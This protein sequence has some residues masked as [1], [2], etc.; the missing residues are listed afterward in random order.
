MLVLVAVVAVTS[1]S[2]ISL[3]LDAQSNL[4]D[5]GYSSANVNADESNGFTTVTV[6]VS[7]GPPPDRAARV[8]WTTFPR[9]VDRIVVQTG[10]RSY[11]YGRSELTDRF[12]SR[13]SGYDDKTFGADLGRAVLIGFAVA[14]GGYLL[15]GT[16]ILVIALT[17][18]SRKRRA[19]IAA[20]GY[21]NP[22]TWPPRGPYARSAGNPWGQPQPWNQ[23]QPWSQPPP[24]TG[25]QPPG[26]WTTPP[27]PGTSHRPGPGASRPRPGPGASPRRRAPRPLPPLRHRTT[28][29]RRA[30]VRPR[31]GPTATTRPGRRADLPVRPSCPAGPGRVAGGDQSSN[32]L[33][34]ALT[35]R[36]RR[37]PFQGRSSMNAQLRRWMADGP[38][39]RRATRWR[40]HG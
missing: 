4:R 19:R 24:G 40:G 37:T 1:C 26:T 20:G 35:G 25:G 23:A 17:A 28:A 15:V 36:W 18:W 34:W 9:R 2:T 38:M 8:I 13:P 5:A 29:R 32:R 14:G 10:G 31:P 27:G 11:D 12:G 6:Q 33:P 16:L 30:R 7:G 3:L 21:P 22:A 39:P